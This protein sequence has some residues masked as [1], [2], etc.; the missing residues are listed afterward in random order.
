MGIPARTLPGGKRHERGAGL[1]EYAL[2]LLLISLVAIGA[3]SA[4]GPVLVA[5]FD[6][7][8]GAL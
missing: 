1:A 3:I 5:M 7:V 6:A 8:T 4:L 2:L